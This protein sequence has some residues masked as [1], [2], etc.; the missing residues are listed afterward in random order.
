MTSCDRPT[1]EMSAGKEVIDG[2]MR[3]A[4]AGEEG[5]PRGDRRKAKPKARLGRVSQLGMSPE[6]ESVSAAAPH[7]ASNQQLVDNGAS[8][9]STAVTSKGGRRTGARR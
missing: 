4:Q 1:P 5:G 8:S 3:A 2:E 9:S 7:S 6:R